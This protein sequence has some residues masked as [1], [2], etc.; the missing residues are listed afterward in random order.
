[1]SGT[2]TCWSSRCRASSEKRAL[3]DD[4]RL[5]FF[6]IDHFKGYNAV[7]VQQSRLGEMSRD[8]LAEIITD[9]WL[10]KAPK[11]LAKA[12]LAPADG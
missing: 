10:T 2:T 11:S 4:E 3:V 1:M 6:T 5:P 7:L 9:A 12:F 8:E